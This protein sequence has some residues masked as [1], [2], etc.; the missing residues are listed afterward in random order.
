VIPPPKLNFNEAP[1]A[2]REM[3]AQMG[4]GPQQTR[5]LRAD[6]M[7]RMHQG[8]VR[9]VTGT[10]S[11][12]NPWL[13]HGDL[14]LAFSL[15][16]ESGFSPTEVLAAAAS[17]AARTCGVETGKDTCAPGTTPPSSWSTKTLRASPIAP[18]GIKL[19]RLGGSATS[20]NPER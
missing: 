1:P 19:I 12:L 13:A 8:G 5:E 10:D 14:H 18:L 6:M 3:A 7:R 4:V 2:V 17:L 15:L 20:S 16:A 9:T 11:G